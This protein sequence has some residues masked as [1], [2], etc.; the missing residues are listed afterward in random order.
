MPKSQAPISPEQ[1]CRGKPGG[2]DRRAA[3]ALAPVQPGFGGPFQLAVEHEARNA[4]RALARH[5]MVD[6]DWHEGHM[7]TPLS[8]WQSDGGTKRR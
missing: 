1:G 7:E 2:R 6:P 8:F 5:R 3:G 4:I